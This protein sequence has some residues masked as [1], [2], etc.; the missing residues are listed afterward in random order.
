MKWTVE[1]VCADGRNMLTGKRT[2][3]DGTLWAVHISSAYGPNRDMRFV[4]VERMPAE[5]APLTEFVRASN[6]VLPSSRTDEECKQLALEMV[7]NWK[8]KQ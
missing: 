6:C 5:S 8:V 1:L 4:S 7:A 2:D 3:A